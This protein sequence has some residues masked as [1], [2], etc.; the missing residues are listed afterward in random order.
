MPIFEKLQLGITPKLRMLNIEVYFIQMAQAR[1]MGV[2]DELI[3]RVE[4][5]N[6]EKHQLLLVRRVESGNEPNLLHDGDVILTV[7]GKIVTRM[8]D[9]DVQYT[10]EELDM[11]YLYNL[12]K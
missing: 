12:S 5:A 1:N 8:Q 2:S 4:D 7:N 9:L 6:L 3:R 11:V 10:S